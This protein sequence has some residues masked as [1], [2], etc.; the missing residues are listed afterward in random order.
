MYKREMS[1][2]MG[3]NEEA[4]DEAIDLNQTYWW[5]DKFR[6]RKPRY[7]NRVH[8]G[9]VG[10]WS[11]H[12]HCSFMSGFVSFDFLPLSVRYS[13]QFAADTIGINTTRP[14][15]TTTIRLQKWCKATNST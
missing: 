11:G 6:P 5:H 7:F 15:M 9:Y 12:P 13:A 14:I 8:T 2:G 3:D 10:S 4:F 1:K